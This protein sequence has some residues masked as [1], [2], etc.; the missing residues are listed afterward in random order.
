MID[1]LTGEGKGNLIVNS[2]MIYKKDIKSYPHPGVIAIYLHNTV[3][4]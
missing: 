2:L 3:L 4:Y 1:K